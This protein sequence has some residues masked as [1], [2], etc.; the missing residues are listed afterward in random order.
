MKSAGE[1]KI[2]TPLSLEGDKEVAIMM[3]IVIINLIRIW[4]PPIFSNCSCPS[5]KFPL[6]HLFYDP[7]PV[8]SRSILA[9]AWQYDLSVPNFRQ[10]NS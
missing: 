1:K 9:P 3:M 8:T 10:I 7:R 5:Y 4:A 2:N 6:H